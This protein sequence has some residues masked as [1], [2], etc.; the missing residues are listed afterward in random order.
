MGLDETGIRFGINTQMFEQ[1]CRGIPEDD[2]HGFVYYGGDQGL[3]R[4]VCAFDYLTHHER[5]PRPQA[6]TQAYSAAFD[7]DPTSHICRV[8]G[9]EAFEHPAVQFLLE[10]FASQGLRETKQRVVPKF[11]R[12]LEQI[13]DE[14]I[15][16]EDMNRKVRAFDAGTRFMRLMQSEHRDRR[17]RAAVIVEAPRKNPISGKLDPKPIDILPA[18]LDMAKGALTEE[19]PEE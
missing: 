4:F 17:G 8:R 9:F 15:N 13:L 5:A 1:W 6:I 3:L 7:L 16:D 19:P 2:Q 12:L 14:G 18:T 10:Q 11:S